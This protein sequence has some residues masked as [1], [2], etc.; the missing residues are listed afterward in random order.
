MEPSIIISWHGTSA[1]GQRAAVHAF[2]AVQPLAGAIICSWPVGACTRSVAALAPCWSAQLA[3]V[4]CYWPLQPLGRTHH[5]F[6][7]GSQA[8][9]VAP[10]VAL[11]GWLLKR[12]W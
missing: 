12:Q 11:A 8:A 1:M 5:D 4:V 2:F 3:V 6:M 10:F 9:N 7:F